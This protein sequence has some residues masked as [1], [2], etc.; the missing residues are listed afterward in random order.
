[1]SGSI[2]FR[3]GP[4]QGWTL[5]LHGAYDGGQLVHTLVQLEA[6]YRAGERPLSG[7]LTFAPGIEGFDLTRAAVDHGGPVRM[8]ELLDWVIEAS[9]AALD[10]RTD[11]PA[12]QRAHWQA[13][14]DRA[15]DTRAD[16]FARYPDGTVPAFEIVGRNFAEVRQLAGAL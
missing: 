10:R 8:A 4:F 2:T 1:M 14:V 12:E 16:F 15:D 7:V 9:R 6:P 13:I 11:I 5:S 3:R